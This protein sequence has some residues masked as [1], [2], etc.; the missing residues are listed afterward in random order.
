ME[1]RRERASAKPGRCEKPV[2]LLLVV[3]VPAVPGGDEP[4][5]EPDADAD[6]D[7]VEGAEAPVRIGGSVL[8]CMRA[9]APVFASEG[10]RRGSN[11]PGPRGDGPVPARAAPA[12]SR[13]D[14]DIAAVVAG[15]VATSTWRRR[16]EAMFNGPRT[17]L[18]PANLGSGAALGRRP[19]GDRNASGIDESLAAGT[20]SWPGRRGMPPGPIEPAC[21]CIGCC[22]LA[23]SLRAGMWGRCCGEGGSCSRSSLAPDERW[24]GTLSDSVDRDA[25]NFDSEDLLPYCRKSK[26]GNATESRP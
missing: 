1:R 7:A 19:D 13:V 20:V 18:A 26:L 25:A 3:A 6:V 9:G 10:R 14:T 5:P 22:D 12:A 23:A 21:C 17:P 4:E 24:L 15:G 2:S 16:L 8:G 11:A